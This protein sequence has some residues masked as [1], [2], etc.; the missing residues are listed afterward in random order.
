MLHQH[1]KPHNP[2]L[3]PAPIWQFHHMC[4]C[5]TMLFKSHRAP[6]HMLDRADKFYTL[7][8]NGSKRYSLQQPTQACLYGQCGHLSSFATLTTGFFT[9]ISK[10]QRWYLHELHDP[11][12]EF[13]GHL[14]VLTFFPNFGRGT[15]Y[16]HVYE[17]QKVAIFSVIVASCYCWIKCTPQVWIW[18]GNFNFSGTFF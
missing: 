4:S 18:R 10:T 15:M 2:I 7:D 13:I 8:L 1:D 11:V 12:A 16:I 5:A 9:Q 17:D 6:F 3:I 14:T